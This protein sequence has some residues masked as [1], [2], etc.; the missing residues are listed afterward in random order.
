[1]RTALRQHDGAGAPLLD[2]REHGAR[3]NRTCRLHGSDL[4]RRWERRGAQLRRACLRRHDQ[5]WRRARTQHWMLAGKR[6]AR[7]HEDL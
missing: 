7:R 2:R 6:A 3:G 4:H 5:H 1:V